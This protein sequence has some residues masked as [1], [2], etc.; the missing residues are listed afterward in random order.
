[1]SH[2]VSDIGVKT[3]PLKTNFPAFVLKVESTRGG[4]DS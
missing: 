1:M 3:Q 4:T 2:A